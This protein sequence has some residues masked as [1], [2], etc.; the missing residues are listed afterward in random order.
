MAISG[1]NSH[2]WSQIGHPVPKNPE[3]TTNPHPKTPETP[4][5]PENPGFATNSGLNR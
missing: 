1:N 2:T 4:E 5:N 3:I